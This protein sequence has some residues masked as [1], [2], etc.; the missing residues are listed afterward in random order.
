A[1]R[2]HPKGERPQRLDGASLAV[3]LTQPVARD[4]A[5]TVDLQTVTKQRRPAEL[6]HEG[7]RELLEGVGEDDDGRKLTQPVE[8]TLRAVES[9]DRIDRALDVREL[10][11]MLV[12]DGDSTAHELV[13]VGLVACGALERP[14]ARPPCD[15]DPD[16][17]HEDSFEVETRDEHAACV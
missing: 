13:I 14:D 12:E 2:D 7:F 10:Q 8:K 5:A 9:L 16:L 1:C 4:A 6:A 11:A 17:G 3:L 15:V